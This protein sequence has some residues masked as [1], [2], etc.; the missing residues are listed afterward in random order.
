MGYRNYLYKI[1]KRK[2]K[3]FRNLTKEELTKKYGNLDDENHVWLFDVLGKD[4][5]TIFEFGKLY[6]DDTILRIESTGEPLFTNEEVQEEFQDFAPYLVGKKALL[7]A[8]TIYNNKIK[9]MYQH[10]FD[11][12]EKCKTTEEKLAIF[13]E[14]C[15]EYKRWWDRLYVLNIEDNDNKICNSWLYE[16]LIFE[17]VHQLKTID[18]DKYDLIFLGY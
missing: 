13:E 17:L 3:E 16:H 5:E 2:V 11:E 8:I 14:H 7:E 10:L 15:K 6:W 9:E 1:E 4:I 12:K 18:F